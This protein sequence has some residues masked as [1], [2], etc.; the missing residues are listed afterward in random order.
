M[1]KTT[2][3]KQVLIVDAN[4]ASAARLR[5]VLEGQG[6]RAVAGD[7][8]QATGLARGLKLSL[9]LVDGALAGPDLDHLTGLLRRAAVPVVVLHPADDEPPDVAGAAGYLKTP[10]RTSDLVQTLYRFAGAAV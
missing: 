2:R 1:R 7:V 6:Y 8:R 3:R 10:W 4:A 5:G 9:A